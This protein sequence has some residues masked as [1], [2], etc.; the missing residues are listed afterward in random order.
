MNM[1]APND[2]TSPAALLRE[3]MARVFNERDAEQRFAA[4]RELYAD[5][6][7]LYEPETVVSGHQAISGAVGELLATL[8]PDMMF[9]PTGAEDSHHGLAFARWQGGPAD[10]PPVV[11][12]MDVAHIEAGRITAL[13]VFLDAPTQ[14]NQS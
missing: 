1:T 10:G 6:A 7:T 4:V 12:G 13:Y 3:N 2:T 8:P 11:T 5:N 14:E 9:T